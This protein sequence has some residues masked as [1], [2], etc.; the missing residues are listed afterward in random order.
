M[1]RKEEQAMESASPDDCEA[2]VLDLMNKEMVSIQLTAEAKEQPDEVDVLVSDLLKQMMTD[3]DQA[4]SGKTTDLEEID[5]LLLECMTS[6]KKDPSSET[7]NMPPDPESE[8]AHFEDRDAMLAEFM[9]IQ[10]KV[11]A[12]G[13]STS[14]P[15]PESR[16]SQ[17][18]D[19]DPLPAEFMSSQE[20][21]PAAA[22]SSAPL[23]SGSEAARFAAMDAMLADYGGEYG[24]PIEEAQ[25]AETL[26]APPN[27][28]PVPERPA[29][30]DVQ[31]ADPTLSEEKTS[32]PEN[33]TVPF[34]PNPVPPEAE[35]PRWAANI[36]KPA[37][38][39]A[40]ISEFPEDKISPS[41]VL[42][43]TAVLNSTAPPSAAK[44]A[45]VSKVLLIAA[46]CI[47]VLGV[48]ALPGHYFSGPS[49]K[50]QKPEKL[51]PAVAARQPSAVSKATPNPEVPAVL[52]SQVSP[53]YPE[54]A[55]K[56][57]AAASVVLD[58]S[59][60]S[61]GNVVKATPVSGP[62]LFH[63]EAIRAVMKWRYKPASIAGS[64]VPSRSR[65]TFNFSVKN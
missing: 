11:S 53:K 19:G 61:D 30:L 14:S 46:A 1:S 39:T 57:R 6:E 41:E 42:P 2:L 17:S 48:V 23:G 58:L 65:V 16:F 56:E 9:A 38:K 12:A 13:K 34:H 59:I 62:E 20:G 25:S 8:P 32:P 28:E 33:R 24:T 44:G 43:E 45:P 22:D 63:R 50:S 3:P 31:P 60:D 15:E 47:C 10:E 49:G 64:N 27:P 18:E 51:Q 5:G 54:L 40:A 52:I 7:K 26:K 21:T 55:I 37:A 36:R 29:G 35:N 4:Q